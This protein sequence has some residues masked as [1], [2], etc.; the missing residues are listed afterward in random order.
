MKVRNDLQVKHKEEIKLKKILQFG[1]VDLNLAFNLCFTCMLNKK[2]EGRKRRLRNRTKMRI[3]RK[4]E[5]E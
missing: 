5:E 2:L 4:I 1:T 3:K